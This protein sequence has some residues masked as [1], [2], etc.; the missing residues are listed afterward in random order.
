MSVFDHL[1]RQLFF[2]FFFLGGGGVAGRVRGLR[3]AGKKRITR[4][5]FGHPG[6][7]GGKP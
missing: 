3:Y 4:M 5:A 7:L 6:T 1:T 2:F